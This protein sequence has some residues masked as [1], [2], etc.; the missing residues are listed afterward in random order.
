[1]WKTLKAR[2]PSLLAAVALPLAVGAASAWASGPMDRYESFRRPPLSPPGAVFPV[3]WSALYLLMGVASWRVWNNRSCPQRRGAL[4]LYGAQLAVNFVW[5]LLFFRWERLGTAFFAVLLLWA[6]V[7][8]LI[9][10]FAYCDRAAAWMLLPYLLWLTFA[11][12][13]SL[14]TWFL[15]PR[16]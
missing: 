4:I 7:F 3:V 10:R 13:L 1:M 16:Y 8:A 11:A 9:H 6:M 5:P 14:G 12:Y 15:N 2:L